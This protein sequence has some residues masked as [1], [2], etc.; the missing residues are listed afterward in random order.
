MPIKNQIIFQNP[1]APYGMSDLFEQTWYG[2]ET[3]RQIR[4]TL[5]LALIFGDYWAQIGGLS[6]L[7]LMFAPLVLFLSKP[8]NLLKSPLVIL[9][10][11]A[12]F[13][14]LCWLLYRP[15]TF[16]P[17]YFLGCILLLTVPISKAVEIF[18]NEYHS[19]NRFVLTIAFIS[20]VSTGLFYSVHVFLPK[21]T[22]DLLMYNQPDCAYDPVQCEISNHLNKI[23]T[24]GE[25]IFTND[26]YRYWLR[27]DLIQCALTSSE[28]E[29]YFSLQTSEQRWRFIIGRGFQS[30]LFYN[31]DIPI[32]NKIKE[33]LLEIPTWL[34]IKHIKTI[35]DLNYL[36]LFPKEESS[37]ILYECRQVFHPAWD[38][39]ELTTQ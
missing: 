16:A 29:N 15:A 32:S 17:R 39:I 24:P 5:P 7:I 9:S 2:S 22:F 6:P 33:D 34:D 27:A 30:I 35:D 38:V 3:I 10:I 28:M 20:I 21:Q 4:F 12:T 13:G 25:R 14:L 31:R 36:Q 23:I 19:A 26:F 18:T 8:P 11:A 1:L 37:P